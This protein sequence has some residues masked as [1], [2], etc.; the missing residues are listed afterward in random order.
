MIRIKLLKPR[1]LLNIVLPFLFLS[2]RSSTLLSTFLSTF[3]FTYTDECP[4]V[5]W[6][7]KHLLLIDSFYNHC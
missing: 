7:S 4:I 2:T 6:T 3:S 5:L 1:T